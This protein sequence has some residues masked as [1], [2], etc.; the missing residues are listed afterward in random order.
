MNAPF[1]NVEITGD[2]MVDYMKFPLL[3]VEITLPQL[4]IVCESL[5]LNVSSCNHD[6]TDFFNSQHTA[7]I[8]H[9]AVMLERF[10][11]IKMNV[12]EEIE[13]C[14]EAFGT[15]I[16]S[17]T[18]PELDSLVIII[19]LELGVEWTDEDKIADEHIS[20]LLQGQDDLYHLLKHVQYHP[21]DYVF[22][23]VTS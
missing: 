13:E 2:G 19:N 8:H 20:E 21:H 11:E 3:H 14:G 6:E 17:M 18:P 23:A 7:L 12:M 9:S 15:Q 16:I 10:H 22:D 5:F 4:L 1:L